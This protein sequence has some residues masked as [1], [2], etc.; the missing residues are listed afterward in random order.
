MYSCLTAFNNQ[1]NKRRLRS[2]QILMFIFNSVL[3]KSKVVGGMWAFFNPPATSLLRLATLN[4]R[5][6]ISL[7]R[8]HNRALVIGGLH[9]LYESGDAGE[10][11]NAEENGRGGVR[12]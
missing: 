6:I 9:P 7:H 4:S 8:H 2:F 5:A 11:C 12:A 10:D 1:I 3:N